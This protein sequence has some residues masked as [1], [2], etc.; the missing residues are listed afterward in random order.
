[1]LTLCSTKRIITLQRLQKLDE[2]RQSSNVRLIE[3]VV[4]KITNH[5]GYSMQFWRD[6]EICGLREAIMY[7]H[8]KYPVSDEL[9]KIYAEIAAIA[10]VN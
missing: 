4:D 5:D 2:K 6:V 9:V 8:N 3:M 7:L 10:S 1:M